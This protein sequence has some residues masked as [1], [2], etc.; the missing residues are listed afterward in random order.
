MAL[1][2]EFIACELLK[3]WCRSRLARHQQGGSGLAVGAAAALARCK[4]AW[5]IPWLRKQAAMTSA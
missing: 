3:R 4:P 1:P 2:R 5:L